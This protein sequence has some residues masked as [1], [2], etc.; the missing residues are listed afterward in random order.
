MSDR[1]TDRST[2]TARGE[3]R[4]FPSSAAASLQRSIAQLRAASARIEEVLSDSTVP[5]SFFRLPQPSSTTATQTMAETTSGDQREVSPE[6]ARLLFQRQVR[7]NEA[8]SRLDVVRASFLPVPPTSS[9]SPTSSSSGTTVFPSTSSPQPFPLLSSPSA[10]SWNNH[11]PPSSSSWLSNRL[12]ASL[13]RARTNAQQ[14]S[15]TANV[16]PPPAAPTTRQTPPSTLLLSRR[17]FANGSGSGRRAWPVKLDMNGEEIHDED[18]DDGEGG[19][20]VRNDWSEDGGSESEGGLRFRGTGG[21]GA[22]RRRV[23]EE[24]C[25]R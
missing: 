12:E 25:G 2:N 20:G 14:E 19:Y 16:S 13:Q 15:T 24:M 3:L 4:A 18:E 6:E 8:R 5:R 11:T 22:G 9:T 21:N 10:P 23:R 1:R 7:R 17:P